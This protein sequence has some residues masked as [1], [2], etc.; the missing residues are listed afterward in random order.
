MANETT[1]RS[2]LHKRT[3]CTIPHLRDSMS[4]HCVKQASGH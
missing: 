1:L 4:C 2:S 3:M